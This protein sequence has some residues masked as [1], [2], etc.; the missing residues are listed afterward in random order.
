MAKPNTKQTSD[1]NISSRVG[2]Y[3]SRNII[4]S[5]TAAL[6]LIGAFVL[7]ALHTNRFTKVIQSNIEIQILLEN[8]LDSKDSLRIVNLLASQPFILK[9]NGQ[10]KIRYESKEEALERLSEEL[11]E[12]ILSNALA[13]PLRNSFIINILP[14][15]HKSDK[16]ARIKEQL[17][18][19][20]GIFDVSYAEDVM[21]K[22]DRNI[23]IIGLI[24]FALV[25][26]LVLL[27][28]FFVHTA[29][30]L[31]LYSQ[32]FIIR[33][34]QLV[35]ASDNFIKKPFVVR[36]GLYG[37]LSGIIASVLLTGG[38]FWLYDVLPEFKQ[39][40]D[41]SST[42]LIFLSLL[43]TGA[44]IAALSAFFAVNKYLNRSLDELYRR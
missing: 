19:E 28:G 21:D 32:R 11:Q 40:Q 7:F 37:M 33:S 12:D 16:L 41:W 26:L 4:L 6:L 36:A 43:L 17:T 1:S 2:A 39:V 9:I 3:Q 44:F 29:I 38:L 13:N 18:G 34:M 42:L 24:V 10:P 14:A 30:K 27:T 8:G 23:R 31:A 35:G 22:I 20:P 15:Y 5:I 25:M